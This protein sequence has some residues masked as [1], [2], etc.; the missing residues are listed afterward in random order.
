MLKEEFENLRLEAHDLLAG[1]PVHSLHKVVLPGGRSGMTVREIN[2]LTGF[3]SEKTEVGFV[4][5]A[6][7]WMRGFI[8]RILGWDNDKELIESVSYL[9]RLTAGQR[10]KSLIEPG[11]AEGISR[12]LYCFENEFL[13]EI[14]NRTVHC[15]WLAASEKT[16]DGYVLYMVVYVRR[17]N[18]FTPVY[19]ALVGPVLK[20]IIYPSI[21]K[22]IVRNW[23]K[24]FPAAQEENLKPAASH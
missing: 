17:L 23:K 24:A 6:L 7:F 18:W 8:G 13:A 19:M 12:V 10:E 3:N 4:S 5:E 16:E 9:P 14:I 22:S 21:E 1:V 2:E 20:W 15:F 11:K